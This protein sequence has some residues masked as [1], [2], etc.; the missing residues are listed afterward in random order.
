M[1]ASVV[2]PN[3]NGRHFLE[4]LFGDLGLQT[5]APAE[6]IVV[7]NGSTDGSQECAR[8]AGAR[9]IG[10]DTNRGFAG[11]VNAGVR[12]SR[13]DMVAIL[14]NDLRLDRSWLEAVSTG[15]GDAAFAVGKVLSLSERDRI[16]GTFDAICC[17]G[18]AWRCGAGAPDGPIWS[19]GRVVRIAPFTA[20]LVRRE[21]YLRVGGLDEHFESYLEDVD[22]GLR[23]ASHRYSGRYVPEAVAWHAGSGTLGRWH[24][25]TVRQ[26]ARNQVFLLAR[27]YN[28]E[29]LRA[30][31]WKI[32]VAHLLWGAL[33]FRHGRGLSW[34][35]GKLEG[36]SR[37][38]EMRGGKGLCVPE[39][40]EESEHEMRKLQ[41][42]TGQDLYWRLYF[43]L[44]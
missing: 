34:L 1:R 12:D 44:T 28:R 8:R 6:V 31:G 16:D 36:L 29:M 41:L 18:T 30:Y 27:H 40:L 32:A 22:F 10:F 19:E 25:R 21:S 39:V 2:I 26:I 4:P 35:G 17:G 42:A 9:V 38:R 33:A 43:A 37:C 3:W 23:C 20:I 5:L 14:N 11:A 15:M 24:P 13:H 7:D